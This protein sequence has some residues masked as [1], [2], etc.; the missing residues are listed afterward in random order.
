[1]FFCLRLAASVLG[2]NWYAFRYSYRS[3]GIWRDAA[4]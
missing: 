4:R 1:M 2:A 3:R